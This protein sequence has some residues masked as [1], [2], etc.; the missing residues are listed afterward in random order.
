MFIYIYSR[1]GTHQGKIKYDPD[2]EFSEVWLMI[3]FIIG[4]YTPF[5]KRHYV[6]E[7]LRAKLGKGERK[8]VLEK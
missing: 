3:F 8:Q 5:T 2:N 7:A 4:Y 6:G 1:I